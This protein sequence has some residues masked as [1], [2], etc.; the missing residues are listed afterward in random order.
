GVYEFGS[1]VKS[2]SLDFELTKPFSPLFRALLGSPDINDIALFIP[3]TALNIY[4]ISQLGIEFSMGSILLFG[5]LFL[6]GFFIATA[7][8]IFV[9]ALGILTTEIEN[10]IFLYRD[11]GKQGQ[12]P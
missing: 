7:F 8:H 3:M 6:N 1:K 10:A 5:L 9:L 4:I 11:V 2:G 12:F